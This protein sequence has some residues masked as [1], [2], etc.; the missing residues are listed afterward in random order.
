MR[1]VFLGNLYVVE[2][3]AALSKETWRVPRALSTRLPLG[4]ALDFPLNFR[5]LSP[6]G[7][8]YFSPGNQL[9]CD[10]NEDKEDYPE[11]PAKAARRALG[12]FDLLESGASRRGLFLFDD[13]NLRSDFEGT[14]VF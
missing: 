14:Q 13:S 10:K 8:G 1:S 12:G 5:S 2:R 4:R 9:D 7:L 11:D 3:K 6:C